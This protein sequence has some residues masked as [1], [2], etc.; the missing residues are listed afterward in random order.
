MMITVYGRR[1]CGLVLAAV[2][3]LLTAMHGA[4][5]PAATALVSTITFTAFDTETTGLDSSRQ[6]IVEIGAVRFRHEEI[7]MERSWLIN[8]ARHIPFGVQRIHGITDAMVKDAPEFP[9][10]F[11][12]FTNFI[13][14]TVLL[15]HNARFD[16]S[17]ISA[18]ARAHGLK[19]PS[20]PVI[21]TLPLFRKWFP[22]APS[23][24]I[25]SLVEYL[26]IRKGRFHRATDDSRYIVLIIDRFLDS[27][28]DAT[29]ASMVR[30]ANGVMHFK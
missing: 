22:E 21:D 19:P 16:V 26:H 25:S 28:P 30:D 2:A 7:L 8:P 1:C 14:A 5:E 20:N 13:G 11:V 10:A 9:G 24:S 6:H 17:F 15:A 12:Q 3:L 29:Y 27:H 18:D 23:H 4:A